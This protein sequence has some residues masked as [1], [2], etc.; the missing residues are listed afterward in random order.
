MNY[1]SYLQN[2]SSKLIA[3]ISANVPLITQYFS[4]PVLTLAA[5]GLILFAV[6]IFLL[7]FEPQGFIVLSICLLFTLLVTYKTSQKN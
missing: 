7:V 6:L 2:K 5:E 1:E 3:N 4:I